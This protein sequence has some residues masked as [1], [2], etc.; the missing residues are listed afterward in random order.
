MV[1]NPRKNVPEDK[2]C[3]YIYPEG[4]P[5]AGERCRAIKLK[6]S[7]YCRYH[8]QD[9]E[10][11]DML[12][13]QLEEARKHAIEANTKHGY[14]A[15]AYKECDSCSLK[16]I[17]DYYEKGKK[18]CDYMLNVDK[19][20]LSSLESIEKTAGK[21]IEEQLKRLK[22]MEIFFKTEPEST[23]IFEASTRCAKRVMDMLKDYAVIKEKYEGSKKD[24]N[25]WKKLLEGR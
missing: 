21:I 4:H 16:N 17:C 23:E 18:V 24:T 10:K 19:I 3:E 7:K 6:G 20:D 5:K 13:R 2:Y 12:L 9:P 8:Q 22:K 25:P 11:K 14:Y 15:E 1:R